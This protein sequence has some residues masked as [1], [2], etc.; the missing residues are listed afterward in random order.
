M[1]QIAI[2]GKGSAGKP[3]TNKGVST[4][5]VSMGNDCEYAENVMEMC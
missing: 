3:S 1:R 5:L 2:L 4:A